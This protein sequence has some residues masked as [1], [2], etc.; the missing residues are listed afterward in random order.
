LTIGHSTHSLERFAALL[1]DAGVDVLV[2]VRTVPHSRRM[3]WF[4]GQSLAASLPDFGI[5]YAHEKPLG[6]FRTPRPD[7]VNTGWEA[8]GFR[9]YAD[10]MATP[11]FAAAVERVEALA[12]EGRVVL[13]CA[14]ADQ[15]SCH[16]QLTSD[17]FLV[18]GWKVL[19][20]APDGGL[21][22]HA[23][24]DFAVVQGTTI[25]YPARQHMLDV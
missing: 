18:R 8:D 15:R 24:P 11:A 17:A 22:P 7:S 9:G 16:R 3:P 14:E 4:S 13:M 12:R 10:H 2:D 20:L 23:L 21:E 19:H 25:S 5:A 1:C 6:G